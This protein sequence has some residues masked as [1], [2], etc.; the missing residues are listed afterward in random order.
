MTTN[1]VLAPGVDESAR[2]RFEQAWLRGRPEPIEHFLPPRGDPHYLATLAELVGIELEFAWKIGP[3]PTRR[4]EATDPGE[5]RPRPLRV[6]AYLERFPPLAEPGI[7]LPLLQQEYRARHRYGDGPSG[8]E[9]RDRFPGLV[10]SGR[11]V[12]GTLVE[13]RPGERLPAI[14]G[15][16]ILGVLGRGGMG[17]V[18]R[19]RQVALDRLVALKMIA[20]GAAPGAEELARFRTEARAV[21]SLEH[22]NVVRV[23]EVGEHQGLPFLALELVEGGSLDRKLAGKPQPPRQAAELMAVLAAAVDVVHRRGIVHRDLK[24]ANVLLTADGSPKVSDFGLA[25]RRHAGPGQ[26]RSGAFLGTPA[27]VAPEQAAGKVREVGPAADVYALG[28]ILYELLTGRPPFQGDSSL[29]VL[30]QVVNLEPAPAR[31]LRPGVPRDLDTI[32]LKCLDK[33]PERRYSTAAELADD[34]GRFLRGEPTRARPAGP[35]E[36]LARWA[37]RRRARV[38]LAAAVAVL[39]AFAAWLWVGQRSAGSAPACRAVRVNVGPEGVAG[40]LTQAVPLH[41]GDRLRLHFR[42]PHGSRVTLLWLD[43]EGKVTELTPVVRPAGGDWDEV[44]YP[45]REDDVVRL[46]GPPGTECVLVCAGV[47][48]PPGADDLAAAVGQGPLPA[49]PAGE[50]VL[51]SRDRVVGTSRGVSAPEADPA[52]GPVREV[53]ERLDKVRLQLRERCDFLAGVAFAHRD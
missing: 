46:E 29:D 14:P 2:R 31:S 34:L 41:T 17:V 52:A 10:A 45:P 13:E 5:G 22:P 9:Y 42:V 11:D 15:Y 28:A 51:L 23:Y 35:L 47:D 37:W 1:P 36:R 21:A 53:E 3:A 8:D 16:E 12:E 19:A 39:L 33:R 26:T 48:R 49:L 40:E 6:E 27:Y 50:L 4:G 32:C 7:L 38:G 20:A 18:Y 43:S 30:W 44:R 24:P 25:K